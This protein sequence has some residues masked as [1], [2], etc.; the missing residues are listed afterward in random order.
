MAGA[1]FVLAVPITVAAISGHANA[2]VTQATTSTTTPTP[3]QGSTPAS[4]AAAR[5]LAAE[6]RLTD[7]KLRVCQNRQAAITNIMT[8]ISDRGQKQLDL[9]SGIA[10]RVENFYATKG[11]TLSNYD[12]LVADVK[13]KQAAAQN[14]VDKIKSSST[15]FNCDGTNPMGIA[16]SF[17]SM[18]KIEIASLNDY[19]TSI[20]NLIVGVKSVESTQATTSTTTTTKASTTTA[21]G[22][23]TTK[24]T[25]G[26]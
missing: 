26:N 22:T 17:K 13:A 14:S 2:E 15:S 7:A 8:R 21:S 9:F 10:T 25:R 23:S 16:D 4:Q 5:R 12:T 11:K 24:T 6:T 18:L 3:A 1:L 19:K 20:K